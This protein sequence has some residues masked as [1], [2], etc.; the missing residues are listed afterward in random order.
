[1]NIAHNQTIQT[2]YVPKLSFDLAE[3]KKSKAICIA[4][5]NLASDQDTTT[6]SHIEV[7][8]S[9]KLSLKQRVTILTA[10]CKKHSLAILSVVAITI[11]AVGIIV[12]LVLFNSSAHQHLNQRKQD[13]LDG[14]IGIYKL[15][16]NRWTK[17]NMR[18]IQDYPNW[19]FVRFADLDDYKKESL[20]TSAFLISFTVSMAVL[21]VAMAAAISLDFIEEFQ[22]EFNLN[23]VNVQEKISKQNHDIE[24]LSNLVD[25]QGFLLDPLTSKQIHPDH[26]N[27]PRHIKV[28]SELYTAESLIKFFLSH[29]LEF[30]FMKHPSQNRYLSE[31]EQSEILEK[32]ENILAIEREEFLRCF[33]IYNSHK[34]HISMSITQ[35][36]AFDNDCIAQYRST[37]RWNQPGFIQMPEINQNQFMEQNKHHAFFER[38]L[39]NLK[40]KLDP[41]I[42]RCLIA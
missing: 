24:E 16:T 17:Y 42:L 28:G 40:T 8:Y 19:E 1:M 7:D 29:D 14:K 10:A 30:G 21:A 33:N 25:Q 11:L 36:S 5:R 3:L 26:I 37:L 9:P 34:F 4:M 6:K 20:V 32:L 15:V 2:L 39:S 18:A 22:K 41:S 23:K 27:A 12:A 13:I 31:S 35:K 38:K